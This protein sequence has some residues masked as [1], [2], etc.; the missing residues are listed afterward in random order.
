MQRTKYF[1]FAGGVDEVTAPLA[2]KPGYLIG[3]K[4]YEID[5]SAYAGYR[6]I[7]GYERYDGNQ[8]PSEAPYW[9]ITFDEGTVQILN[10]DVLG[11]QSG[12]GSQTMQVVALADATL[13]SGAW[14]GTGAGTVVVGYDSTTALLDGDSFSDNDPLYEDTTFK[15]RINGS[16]SQNNESDDDIHTTNIRLAIEHSRGLI[17][18]VPGSGAIRGIWMYGGNKYAFRD[19]A[20]GTAGVMHKATATGWTSV[21]LGYE[22]AFTSGGTAA[23]AVGDTVTGDTSTET[24]VITAVVLTSGSWSGGDAAGWLYVHAAPS[25]AFTA[26]ENVSTPT[27]ANIATITTDFAAN[28]LPAGG[29]YEFVNENFYGSADSIK[30]YGCNGVGKAFEF[31]GTNFHYLHTGMTTDTPIHI[32][33]HKKHLFLAFPNGSVQ[34]SSIGVPLEWSVITGAAELGTADEVS[35]FSTLPGNTL[36][37]L[38][39]NRTY[40]LYGSASGGSDPWDL[41]ELSDE[42]GAIEWTIQRMGRPTY[43]DDRGLRDLYSTDKY[44]DFDAD[45]L[46]QKMKRSFKNALSLVQSSVR[47]RTKSQYRLFLTD[48]TFYIVTFDANK[49]AGIM[50]C[51]Y[52]NVVS[53]VCSG[54]NSSGVEEIYFGSD[55]GYVYQMDKG[56]SFDG[57]AVEAFIRPAFNNFGTPRHKKRIHQAILEVSASSAI[58]L[59]FTPD[60]DYGNNDDITQSLTVDVSGTL[61]GVGVWGSFLWGNQDYSDPVAYIDGSGTNLGMVIYSSAIYDEPHTLHGITLHYSNRGL[62]R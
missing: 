36:E 44:G 21:A 41:R 28:T 60:F 38:N 3:S 20:G 17:S 9:K 54:E 37:I 52:D 42:A 2:L 15:A 24:A 1:P 62:K 39:R 43:L 48:N 55:D 18:A 51:E 11:E 56:T 46:S 26:G 30:M 27:Q 58:T 57:G 6:R 40:I 49:L 47:V 4:N 25:G 23:I 22:V 12:A 31:D 61:W 53:C 10:G 32:I 16:I 29:R 14:D 5:S 45:V 33:Q 8:R 34:H 59:Q 13:T 7:D 35:G 19:N 50:P